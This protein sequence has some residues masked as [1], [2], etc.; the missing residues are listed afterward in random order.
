MENEKYIG[1]SLLKDK[2]TAP[3][4]FKFKEK[5]VKTKHID[6]KAVTN[7][8][9]DDNAVTERTILDS[10]VTNSKIANG[11][12]TSGK[13]G[14]GEV[15]N[16]NIGDNQVTSD[17]IGA[18][19]VK[20]DNIAGKAVTTAKI[21]DEAV[22]TIQIHNRAVTSGKIGVQEVHTENIKDLNVT[23]PKL[24]EG[25]VTW[26]K[27]SSDAKNSISDMVDDAADVI[28]RRLMRDVNIIISDYRPI[29]ITG[30]VSN[31]AD[32][33]D[34]TSVNIGGTDV[35]RLK[36]KEYVPTIYSGLGKKYLRKNLVG[37]VNILTQ[38]MMPLETGGNT[39]YVIQYDY[40]LDGE[41]IVV[42]EGCTL[43][44]DGGSLSNGTLILQDTCIEAYYSVFHTDLNVSGTA[45]NDA[46]PDWFAG[47]DA[48]RIEKALQVFCSIKLAA[49]D[50][51]I[52]RQIEVTNSFKMVGSGFGDFFGEGNDSSQIRRDMSRTRLMTTDAFN[53]TQTEEYVPAIIKVKKGGTNQRFYSIYIEGVSFV[54]KSKV[55]Y[56]LEICTPNGPSRP[57]SIVSCNFKYFSHAIDINNDGNDGTSSSPTSTNVGVFNLTKS[58]ITNNDYGLYVSG[59]HALMM[60]NIV[61]NNLEANAEAAIYAMDY[62]LRPNNTNT[63]PIFGDINIEDNLLEGMQ[64]P[65]KLVLGAYGHLRLIG[66]YFETN[67]QSITNIITTVNLTDTASVFLDGNACTSNNLTWNISG[68]DVYIRDVSADSNFFELNRCTMYGKVPSKMLSVKSTIFENEPGNTSSFTE[69][70]H[71]YPPKNVVV[72]S[73]CY[74]RD[75]G[76]GSTI[77]ATLT[78][79]AITLTAGTYRLV[80]KVQ[81]T[82]ADTCM[83]LRFNSTNYTGY[84]RNTKSI[85]YYV[86][87]MVL[88]AQ[89]TSALLL[90]RKVYPS[91][92]TASDAVVVKVPDN[93]PYLI[94]VLPS[95]ERNI[96]KGNIE[97]KGI[98]DTVFDTNLLKSISWTG[99]G[100]VDEN[101]Y[102]ANINKG[103]T[104]NRP[105]VA[106]YDDD[107]YEYYDTDLNK[108]INART[109]VGSQA[110]SKVINTGVTGEHVSN[111]CINGGYY[112]FN[113]SPNTV[114]N[115]VKM[116]FR[117][118]EDDET[119]Q[120]IVINSSASS[121]NNTIIQAP[122]PTVYPFIYFYNGRPTGSN[123]MTF[124]LYNINTIWKEQDGATA[125]VLRSGD[126]ASRPVGGD[127]YVGFMYMD[128]EVGKPVYAK[129]I[130]GATVTWVDATGEIV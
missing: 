114:S 102:T 21:N 32:E 62:H 125:G 129:V 97:V 38:D 18:G 110:L 28:T 78:S 3:L 113:D 7:G 34:L 98:G 33:E 128:T 36:D 69:I 57:V 1:K 120:I 127:I 9:I 58:N 118:A 14:A 54:G 75:Y 130:S 64:T 80:S 121:A 15:K 100:W 74:R 72:D 50:Y 83:Y 67:R 41:E 26:S 24:A 4:S 51:M 12:V 53:A 30:D 63:H 86:H 123:K 87:D 84:V 31:A 112:R 65:I 91:G 95:D 124:T 29:E 59:N 101:G 42:P 122:D 19:E 47:D 17:K 35:I 27:L 76:D 79:S 5:S 82:N 70:A 48:S 88:D 10:N 73:K 93:N 66:N 61:G 107:G 8:Q 116:I 85:M 119:D 22:N 55:G 71:W 92:L 96:T 90:R 25:N 109:S 103:T 89:A 6:D 117:K 44:F 60:A 126:T 2:P 111:I 77:D 45:F 16:S 52:D 39:I 81:A 13:I 104:A 68:C 20:T 115:N 46:L 11:A 40:D 37:G 105:S 49:R 108:S 23:T 56:G 43:E 99:S 106:A 94:P